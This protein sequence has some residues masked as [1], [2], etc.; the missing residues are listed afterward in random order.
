MK[1]YATYAIAL[2]TGLVCITLQGCS[3]AP[4]PPPGTEATVPV[5]E[6]PSATASLPAASTTTTAYAPEIEAEFQRGR[7]ALDQQQWQAAL[8]ANSAVLEKVPT[9]I[10]AL[11]HRAIALTKLNRLNVA[12]KDLLAAQHLQPQNADIAVN[13]AG[14]YS[15]R[16][17]N[18]KAIASLKQAV[19]LGF[20][21]RDWLEQDPD[22]EQ[23]RQDSRFATLFS[24]AAQ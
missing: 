23:V 13:L 21:R 15:L 11:Q 24:A 1:K 8:E 18:D 4:P 5:Q 22:L 19:H 7:L 12:E 20:N 9:H 10:Q 3:K 16:G 14:I 2:G 17:D 6:K